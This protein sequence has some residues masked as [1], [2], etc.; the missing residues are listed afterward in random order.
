MTKSN[1]NL[2]L[3]GTSVIVPESQT[4]LFE[5]SLEVEKDGESNLKRI[6]GVKLFAL[7]KIKK[8]KT[9]LQCNNVVYN[10]HFWVGRRV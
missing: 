5:Y 7:K 6:S 1:S 9:V 2:Y 10:N 8:I 4:P 3:D